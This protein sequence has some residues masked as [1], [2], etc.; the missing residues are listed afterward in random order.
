MAGYVET[1]AYDGSNDMTRMTVDGKATDFVYAERAGGRGKYVSEVRDAVAGTTRYQLVKLDPVETRRISRTGKVTT[2][3]SKDGLTEGIR[4]PLGSLREVTFSDRLPTQIQDYR[5][6][7]KRI[8]YDSRG[9]PLKVIDAYN[10][11]TRLTYDTSDNLLTYTTPSPLNHTWYYSYDSQGNLVSIRSPLQAASNSETRLNYLA[12]GRLHEMIPPVGGRTS[13]DYDSYG[14]QTTVTDPQGHTVRFAYG[15][16]GLR[17][18][19]ITDARGKT[20][21][22]TYDPNDRLLE[23]TYDTV[24]G[25]PRIRNVYDAFNQKDFYDENNLKTTVE[26]NRFGYITRMIPPLGSG[27]ATSYEYDA[28]NNRTLVSDALGRVTRTEYDDGGRPIR[29]LEPGN[30]ETV[31]TYDAEGNLTA[32]RDPRGNS[33][34]LTYD[35]NNRLLTTRYPVGGT[36]SHTRDVVGRI[37]VTTNGRGETVSFQYDADGRLVRKSFGGTVFTYAYEAAGNVTAFSDGLGSTTYAYNPRREVSSITYPGGLQAAFT[38]DPSGNL[39]SVTYPGGL[40][41]VYTYDGF[42]RVKIPA[43][44]RQA[45]RN[46]MMPTREKRNQIVRMAWGP[47]SIDF[48]YDPAARLTR[49]TRSNGTVTRYTYDAGSRMTSL[50]HEKQDVPFLNLTYGYD[51]AGQTTSTVCDACLSPALAATSQPAVY[52]AANR[53]V[54]LGGVAHDHDLDG[55]LTGMGGGRFTAAYDAENRPGQ[56]TR[57]GVVTSYA[58]NAR[59]LLCR[60]VRNDKTR[61]LHYDAQ[62]RLLFETDGNHTVTALYLHAGKSL[63]AQVK[64][65]GDPLFHHF[66]NTGNTLALT[67]K[68]GSLQA[69]YAYE[70]FGRM[71]ESGTAPFNPFTFSGAFGVLSEGQGLYVTKK[72]FYDASIGRFLQRDPIGFDG[73]VHLYMYAANNPLTFMDPAGTI[74]GTLAEIYYSYV[75]GSETARMAASS[76]ETEQKLFERVPEGNSQALAKWIKW[77]KIADEDYAEAAFGA[78][79]VG[80]TLVKEGIKAAMTAPMPDGVAGVVGDVLVDQFIDSDG[81]GGGYIVSDGSDGGDGGGGYEE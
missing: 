36:V 16:A 67:D 71:T 9:N 65:D 78:G 22:L 26:R 29:T 27:F 81:E 40:Q 69:R 38:Y 43:R 11:E 17:C 41:V 44:F 49:E 63:A 45:G 30:T 70:P 59:G 51:T 50:V 54:S 55:N 37:S 68:T 53:L 57:D 4:D 12:N 13:F 24:A 47:H 6:K 61:N 77:K 64:P 33:T 20:K 60:I 72:R 8:E 5:G 48:Q 3:R 58:Y 56:V 39:A 31:R 21:H 23:V 32:L 62:D 19:S 1:Y 2:F 46:Q 74:F 10:R 73:G 76:R 35:D 18:E 66:D 14:N 42:N 28:D 7:T 34:L 25:S 52:D 80:K 75:S 79:Q 15:M